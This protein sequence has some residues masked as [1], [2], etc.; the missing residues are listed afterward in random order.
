MSSVMTKERLIR[1]LSDPMIPNDTPV[2]IQ[3]GSGEEWPAWALRLEHPS[4]YFANQ[5]VLTDQDERG[6][7]DEGYTHTD[8]MVESDYQLI[9]PIYSLGQARPIARMVGKPGHM[10]LIES[11]DSDG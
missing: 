1:L 7:G 11:K 2:W 6:L 10:K 8:R 3:S 9:E 5:L 4:T